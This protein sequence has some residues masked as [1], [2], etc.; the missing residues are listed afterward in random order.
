MPEGA[1]AA[2][3]PSV[4]RKELSLKLFGEDRVLGTIDARLMTD[5]IS[6]VN[7]HKKKGGGRTR[8]TDARLDAVDA[9]LR[10]QTA[11]PGGLDELRSTMDAWRTAY[12]AK[13]DAAEHYDTRR[14]GAYTDWNS[15][16][17]EMLSRRCLELA[18]LAPASGPG[19]CAQH[20]SGRERASEKRRKTRTAGVALDGQE[21]EGAAAAAAA[22]GDSRGVVVDVGCGT[23]LSSVEAVRLGHTVVGFDYSPSMLLAAA[24]QLVAKARGD[25]RQGIPVRAGAA[26]AVVS[27]GALHYLGDCADAAASFMA[28]VRRVLLQADAPSGS[29]GVFVAQ[30][31][32]SAA[33]DA[34][35]VA[36]GYA[37]AAAD[38]GLWPSLLLDQPHRTD[39]K[40]WFL[41]AHRLPDGAEVPPAPR[42]C[43]VHGGEAACSLTHAAACKAAGL[44][45]PGVPSGTADGTHEL[46]VWRQ[47][48]RYAHKLSRTYRHAVSLGDGEAAGLSAAET[49]LAQRL[50]QLF[51]SEPIVDAS[52][53]KWVQL[54]GVLHGTG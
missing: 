2:P 54:M 8:L 18:G 39:A 4:R 16:S 11:F 41:V 50:V 28:D 33:V 31:F 27:V 10:A 1:A 19:S 12:R 35:A 38:A 34:A 53:D 25:L 46:W 44:P 47:H 52:A 5:L 15:G 26:A 40:R 6:I 43:P 29:S 24:P 37:A 3:A 14:A 36:R 21:T 32:P 48:L 45:A 49:A 30:F 7:A 17:Q 23:G 51:G 42:L 20:K 9:E 22:P 13:F